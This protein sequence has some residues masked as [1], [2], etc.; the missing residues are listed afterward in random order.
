MVGEKDETTSRIEELDM[1]GGD[2]YLFGVN[3]EAHY[4]FNENIIV[5]LG[6]GYETINQPNISYIP[7]YISLR[8]SIG[9]EK[10]EAPIFRVDVGTQFGDLAR[11]A[12]LFRIGV[13]YRIPVYKELCVNIEGILTY[14][15]LRK[16]FVLEP[17]VVQYYNM[18][19][20]GIS[21]GFEL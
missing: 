3:I 18:N 1:G 13:G 7:V 8:S 17:G 16:E 5:G 10:L 6:T 15:G 19:G 21:A 4:R 11:T 14:Q 9:A 12:P 20:F 2:S